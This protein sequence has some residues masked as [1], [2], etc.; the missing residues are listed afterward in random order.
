MEKSLCL[1]LLTTI[2]ILVVV[3]S[4]DG[5]N[6]GEHWCGEYY[7][8]IEDPTFEMERCIEIEN[9]FEDTLLKN[10]INLHVLQKTFISSSYPSPNLLN[11]IYQIDNTEN[12]SA[13][14]SSSHVFTVI[15]PKTLHGLQ[16]GIMAAIFYM[17]GIILPKT[18]V[19]YLNLSNHNFTWEEESYG[20]V[21]LT[22]KVSDEII[23]ILYILAYQVCIIIIIT[24]FYTM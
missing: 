14:W 22:E 8:E 3:Q 7:I 19:L 9:I 10:K 12:V 2:Y 21:T 17:E 1:V 13:T 16:S 5:S 23:I 18:I 11:V 4:A 24:V 15:D 6:H 20:I